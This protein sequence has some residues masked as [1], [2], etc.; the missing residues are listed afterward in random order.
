MIC[1]F[2][3]LRVLFLDESS[4]EDN[5]GR[6]LHELAL[7][8]SSLEVLNFYGTD[9]HD[10]SVADL[11]TL[12]S[13]CKSLYSLKLSELE[14]ESLSMV[15]SRATSLRELGGFSVGSVNSPNQHQIGLPS[16]LTSLV[17]VNYMGVD[18]GD[19]TVNTLVQPIASG[20]KK[21]DLQ[22]AFLSVD[23]HCQFLGRCPN[24]EMLEVV[25]FLYCLKKACVCD[26][27]L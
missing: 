24:L 6:W 14:L 11:V 4:I 17:G 25:Y 27:C 5:G 15:L 20:L 22:C 10:I 18:E 16:G 12:T 8:N 9:L 26:S 3:S 23:G 7:H 21:V 1:I 19:V 13:N 2:R